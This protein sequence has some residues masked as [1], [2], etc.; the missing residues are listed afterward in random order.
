MFHD[1]EVIWVGLKLKELGFPVIYDVHADVS[2][3]ILY[4]P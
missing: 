4:K 3:S 2:K 1:P